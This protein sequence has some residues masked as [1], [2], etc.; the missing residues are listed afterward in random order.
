MAP[1]DSAIAQSGSAARRLG[2]NLEA[3][4]DYSPQVPFTDLFLIS[5]E[6]FT[7]CQVGVDPGCTNSN[8]WDT[9]EAAALDLDANGWVRALPSRSDTPIFTSVA[10][11]WDLPSDFPSGRYVVLYEGEG[12]IEYGLGGT[13]I[14]ELS[15]PGRDVVQVNIS[16]GGILVRITSTDPSSGGDYIRSIRFVAAGD[17]GRLATNRFS[18][19]FLDRLQPYTALRFMDWMC[20]RGVHGRSRP[21]PVTQPQRGSRLR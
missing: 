14:D 6:W 19:R 1:I 18:R 5:R 12:T 15:S 4:T 2:T 13:R 3:V 11:F 7:Q 17:E 20:R 9:G 21:M 16:G 8:S 10:T